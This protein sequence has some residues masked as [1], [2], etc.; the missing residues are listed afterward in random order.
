MSRRFLIA[1]QGA[2]APL[3]NTIT[4]RLHESKMGYWHHMDNIWL[5]AGVAPGVTAKGFAEWL[6][7]TPG[8]AATTY[9]VLEV[10]GESRDYWGRGPKTGWDWMK[11]SWH[12]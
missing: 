11:S 12:P 8:V 9:L 6:E 1:M 7:Q 3:I 4:K 10:S 5:V 2:P